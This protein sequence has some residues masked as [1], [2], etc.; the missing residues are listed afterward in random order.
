MIPD[1]T[2]LAEDLKLSV[3]PLEI[4]PAYVPPFKLPV[5][6]KISEPLVIVVFP[7]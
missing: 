2:W 6:F 1:S 7:V 4:V 5:V 3:P